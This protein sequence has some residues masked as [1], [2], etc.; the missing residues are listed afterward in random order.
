MIAAVVIRS[1]HN[2]PALLEDYYFILL[3]PYSQLLLYKIIEKYR[4]ILQVSPP[5]PS[6][7][8]AQA[9]EPGQAEW[10]H[11][12]GSVFLVTCVDVEG[13]ADGKHD[14]ACDAATVTGDPFLLLWGA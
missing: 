2:F 5:E 3:S 13:E 11:P 8:A 1:Q 12:L 14:T 9:V 4:I 6:W 7:F 10:L